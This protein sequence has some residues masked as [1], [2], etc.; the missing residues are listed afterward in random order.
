MEV[1]AGLASTRDHQDAATKHLGS[2]IIY[3]D[4]RAIICSPATISGYPRTLLG[5]CFFYARKG[6]TRPLLLAQIDVVS[7]SGHR[8][9]AS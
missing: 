2:V 1:I 9:S 3:L 5:N 8:D 4:S 7:T 6:K